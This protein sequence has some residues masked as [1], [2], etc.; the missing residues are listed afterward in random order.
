MSW[1]VSVWWYRAS[2]IRFALIEVCWPMPAVKDS[3]IGYFSSSLYVGFM[4]STF[5]RYRC[6]AWRSFNLCA[7]P[8]CNPL[9]RYAS[10]YASTPCRDCPD[11]M[12]MPTNTRVCFFVGFDNFALLIC[13]MIPRKERISCVCAPPP[14]TRYNPVPATLTLLLSRR[15]SPLFAYRYNEKADVWSFMVIVW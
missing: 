9:F 4:T 5:L 3:F 2:L 13:A 6:T 14:P 1:C 8:L 10:A 15:P 12:S 11:A 7:V